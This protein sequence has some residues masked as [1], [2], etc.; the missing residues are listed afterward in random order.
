MPGC[1]FELVLSLNEEACALGE[2]LCYICLLFKKVTTASLSQLATTEQP[3]HFFPQITVA[4]KTGIS[5]FIAIWKWC[6]AL[7][8]AS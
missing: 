6:E 5:S 4:I 7:S 1:N 2:G 3:F 8:Q